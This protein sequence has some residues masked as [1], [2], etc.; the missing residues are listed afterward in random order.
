MRRL[1][2][3]IVLGLATL[4]SAAL[5]NE[6]ADAQNQDSIVV[7]G[8]RI[9]RT[10]QE[11][12]SSV[13]V[14][15]GDELR[16]RAGADTVNDVLGFAP[17]VLTSGSQNNG[18][19]IRGQNT[20]GILSGVNA[21]LGGS[22]PRTT[23]LV[24]GR[25]LSFNE[26]IF[27]ETGAWD[28]AQVEVFLGPQTTSQG[29]NSVAGI[30]NVRTS[31][32][33]Y[34]LEGAARAIVANY[35]TY[36]FS[37]MANLP[38]VDDQV[39][40]RIA[41]D[42]RHHESFLEFTT[43]P[44]AIGIDPLEDSYATVRAKLLLEPAALPGFRAVL[45]WNYA[46]SAGPQTEQIL[47]PPEGSEA[48]TYP[49]FE[50]VVFATETHT[51]IA[52]LS[53][54]LTDRITL[55]N[56]FTFTWADIL[57]YAPPGL[58][59]AD[60]DRD[61]VTNETLLTYGRAGDQVNGVAGLYYQAAS[62]DEFIDLSGFGLGNGIFTDDTEGLGVFGEVTVSP[63]DRLFLTG[64]LRYQRDRQDRDG[65]F[66]ELNPIAFDRTF[67][68]WLPKAGI[69]YDVSADA[70][71]GF[72]ARRGYNLGGV[73]LSFFTGEIDTF[74]EERLWNYEFYW[75]TSWLDGRLRLN[76]NLF[77]TDFE[78]A[79][80]PVNRV[81]PDIGIVTELAAAEDARSYGAEIQLSY[82]PSRQLALDVALGLLE[83]EIKR[84][85]AEPELEGNAFER[86]PGVTA[87]LGARWE[88]IPELV[89]SVQ[90]R[91]VDDYFSD[92]AN[93]P[94]FRI[95]SHF[96]AN[97]QASYRLGPARLFVYATNL[98]DEFALLQQFDPENANVNDPRE[99][100][101]GIE[102]RF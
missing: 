17:N 32:P 60:I 12:A 53:Y 78:D 47:V 30:I 27:G 84:V 40:L 57:R 42:Y 89:L 15:T 31:D 65:G 28:I 59:V 83:T 88:P 69:A 93:T 96:I 99:Y 64:G 25:P 10:V 86:S 46:D 73:T 35:D 102:V 14:T 79:Q 100:G 26:F 52:D 48:R 18:P 55:S 56:R 39:A 66:T 37:G 98:F 95:G 62:A 36:Q 101:A 5:A 34:V 91:Y 94:A 49:N 68:S 9:A 6:V 43:P 51:A 2:S 44:P 72:E 1:T 87:S 13:V 21:F 80:R 4:P 20:T 22:R 54:D 3:N 41:A 67:D 38:L 81:V 75:R 58:G 74:E 50:P 92:D 97:A 63:A 16:D 76:G 82:V 70:R 11:T 71:I 33:T 7:T 61:E 85:S 45:S 90:G 24:D 23:I 19:T 29:P 8:E 77:Y